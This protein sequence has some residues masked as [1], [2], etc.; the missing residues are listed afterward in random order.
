[1]AHIRS[2]GALIQSIN[3]PLLTCYTVGSGED[4]M[5]HD[6]ELIDPIPQTPHDLPLLVGHTPGSNEGSMRLK[7]L[8]DLFTTLLQKVLDLENVK[9]AQAKETA[10]EDTDTEM[11]VKDKGNCEKGGSTTKIVSTATL[12]ISAARLAVSTAEPKEVA[13]QKKSIT[14]LQPLLTI[15]PKDKGRERQEEASKAALAEMYDG[16]Q[17]QIDADHE[18]A[19]RL[20]H[21]EQ[22]K[23]TVEERSKLLAEF[24]ERRKKQLAKERAEAIR[25]K[26]KR[27]ASSS[28]KHKSPKKQKVN[29]Q[30]S[31]D[32]DKEH[33]KCLKM[34]PDADKA[35][36]YETLDVK[37]LIIDY[38]SQVLE[39]TEVDVLDSHK[40]IMERFP[41]N[42]PLGYDLILWGDLKTL[43]ESSK[44]D[45][46]WRNQQ[47]WKL[48]S[49]K[50]YETCGVNILMLDD[51]LVSINMFVEKSYPLTKEILEKMLSSKLE[52]ETESTLALDLIKFIKLQTKEK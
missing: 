31:K 35:I 36:D 29:D 15:D 18:L 28:S 16:V 49:W 7:E 1:M 4:M 17:A 13:Q 27:A 6:I 5:E 10:N 30:E 43:V 23:Y 41:A 40:I 44:D 22:E 21:E 37:S 8:M 46:I 50:L 52:V 20:T 32:S 24:F 38:E 39:T 2:Q 51:S 12:D 47:D 26:K 14:T 45:E 19:V 11:I 33:R 3:P 9:T 42:D 25:S 48:L 34:V